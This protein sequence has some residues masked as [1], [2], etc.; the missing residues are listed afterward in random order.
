M[1]L[2]NCDLDAD[3][4]TFTNSTVSFQRKVK[5]ALSITWQLSAKISRIRCS[6]HESSKYD[7]FNFW[8]QSRN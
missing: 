6:V 8:A 3:S 2:Q 5:V 1:H 4:E 7:D